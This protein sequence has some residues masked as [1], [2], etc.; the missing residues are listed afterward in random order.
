MK[1]KKRKQKTPQISNLTK[2]KLEKGKKR[3]L[4][5]PV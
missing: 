3:N 4:A 1:E 5:A 2:K